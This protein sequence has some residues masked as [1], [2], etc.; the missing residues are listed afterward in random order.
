MVWCFECGDIVVDF[1]QIEVVVFCF[2]QLCYECYSQGECICVVIV[3]VYKQL[4][5]LQVILLC[6]DFCLLVKFF[7]MEVLEIYDGIVVIKMVVCVFGEWVKVVVLSCECDVDLVGVC[8]G[9]KGLCVQLIICELCGEK[10]D[11]IEYSDDLVIFVQGVLVLV[12]IM[13][14]FVINFGE[15]FYF[16]VI[17]EDEQF[18]LVIGKCGQNVCLV[19]E[20]IG[21]KI[22]IKSEM[23]VKDEVVGVF[24]QLFQV[25]EFIFDLIVVEGVDENFVFVL[26]EVG[27][28]SQ[29]VFVVV[30]VEVLQVVEGVMFEVVQVLFDY[31]VEDIEDVVV[32]VVD[33]GE[34]EGGMMD[35]F[36]FMV[37]FSKV[38][39]EFEL[40]FEFGEEE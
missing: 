11:I 8:V 39:Q 17:V 3:E 1:G 14:V 25:G 16:D 7:E 10:I 6:I 21:V 26:G 30:D 20:L 40:D 35:D 4:K 15:M 19:V 23:D 22:D 31:V 36:D 38:F 12:K 34:G 5:G 37:V 27:Y 33:E 18:L 32:E 2:E 28:G 13:C 24:V 29:E 9:M